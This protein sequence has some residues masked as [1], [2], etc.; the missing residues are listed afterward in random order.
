MDHN[1]ISI[2]PVS[3]TQATS[4]HHS[5][6]QQSSALQPQP[7]Q[8]WHAAS[9]STTT[10][11]VLFPG[12]F[13]PYIAMYFIIIIVLP[14]HTAPSSLLQKQGSGEKCTPVR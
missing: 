12:T 2:L 3:H 11:S 7:T 9:A 5:S 13:T 4:L 14:L 1:F 8:S 10:Q 6:K